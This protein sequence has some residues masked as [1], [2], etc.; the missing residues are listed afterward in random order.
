MANGTPLTSYPGWQILRPIGS[1]SY[2]SVY[3]LSRSVGDVTE[4]AALKVIPIPHDDSEIDYLRSSG[5]TDAQISQ[6]FYQQVRSVS[7]EYNLMSKIRS[8]PNVVR[9]DDFMVIPRSGGIGWNICIRME[10]LTPMLKRMDLVRNETMVIQ[11][12][13]DLCNA[14]VACHNSNIIHRDIKPQNIFV[15]PDGT[16]KLGDF[17]IA[18]TMENTTKATA[19]MGTYSYMAP[20]IVHGQ[21][22][23]KNA[24]IY[25]LG[26]VMYWLL[27]ERRAPFLPLPPAVPL[28]QDQEAAQQRRFSGERIP[29]PKYGSAELQAIVLKACAYDPRNRYSTAGEFMNA[30]LQLQRARGGAPVR[31]PVPV[32]PPVWPQPTRPDPGKTGNPPPAKKKSNI[33]LPTILI[34]LIILVVAAILWIIVANYD[35]TEDADSRD[36]EISLQTPEP[37]ETIPS[38]SPPQTSGTQPTEPEEPT[39]TQTGWHIGQGKYGESYI[40]GK[41]EVCLH[42]DVN[43]ITYIDASGNT[44]Y[45]QMDLSVS[46]PQIMGIN[47]QGIY[48]AYLA[49]RADG[50]A[51][52][53]IAHYSF[54]GKETLLDASCN[55]FSFENGYIIFEHTRE[56]VYPHQVTVITPEDKHVDLG[57]EIWDIE[58]IDGE[59]YYLLDGGYGVNTA[60][61]MRFHETSPQ[62]TGSISLPSQNIM[63]LGFIDSKIQLYADGVRQYYNLNGNPIS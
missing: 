13:I 43:D 7:S 55:K 22:Y 17:G 54:S 53:K 4:R 18:R 20:E 44:T 59:I 10:L 63:E 23:G 45:I 31:R 46:N 37:P 58:T 56:Y 24:D 2:G 19:G 28:H 50:R 33:L 6:S 29:Y 34:A 51:V 61:I 42:S 32:P 39:V 16:F 49:D 3:E 8:N 9:C 11:F 1:G 62:C 27:N 25:S 48:V 30:L 41:Q 15:G 47:D 57:D 26:L 36:T 5:M 14:L 40:N 21:S 52:H 60:Y 38:P 12:G 35:T